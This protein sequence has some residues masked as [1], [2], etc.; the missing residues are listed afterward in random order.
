MNELILVILFVINFFAG[1]LAGTIFIG[2]YIQKQ[3]LGHGDW[4]Y[5]PRKLVDEI[6]SKF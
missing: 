3:V 6:K 2:R 5:S 1:F 4:D